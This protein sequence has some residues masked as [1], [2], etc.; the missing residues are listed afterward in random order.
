[1][2]WTVQGAQYVATLRVLVLSER[3]HEVS[4]HCRKAA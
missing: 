1:M 2:R 4:A 3:W